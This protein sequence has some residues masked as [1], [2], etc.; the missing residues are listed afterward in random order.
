M[1]LGKILLSA[2]A[3]VLSLAA[4]G[5]AAGADWAATFQAGRLAARAGNFAE[6]ERC[7]REAIDIAVNPGDLA[8]TLNTLG[9]LYRDAARYDDAESLFNR[10]LDL[11]KQA[12]DS[13]NIA[14]G[15][16]NLGTLRQVTGRQ[17]EAETLYRQAIHL[18][19]RTGDD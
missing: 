19:S 11:Y 18:M 3:L 8:N 1:C 4:P 5:A 15:L 9:V 13:P 7:L 14:R 2:A 6:A 17:K 12:A 16:N 10:A